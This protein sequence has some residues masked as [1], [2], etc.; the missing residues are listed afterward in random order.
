MSGASLA[1][2]GY[3]TCQGQ[4]LGELSLDQ[5]EVKKI[6]QMAQGFGPKALDRDKCGLEV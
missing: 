5:D 4:W 3:S 6:M 2:P 1:P